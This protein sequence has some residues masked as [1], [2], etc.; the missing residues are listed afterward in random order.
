MN[1]MYWLNQLLKG[2]RYLYNLFFKK[3]SDSQKSSSESFSVAPVGVGESQSP[4]SN[5]GSSSVNA[6]AVLSD[7]SIEIIIKKL[8]DTKQI[9]AIT[10]DMDK[11]KGDTDKLRESQFSII[12]I[13][14]IFV[15]LFTFISVEFQIFRSFTSWKAGASLTLI[16]LGSLLFFI[17]VIGLILNRNLSKKIFGVMFA[18]FIFIIMGVFLFAYAGINNPEYISLEA[19]DLNERFIDRTEEIKDNFY[20]K[21]EVELIL[22]SFKDCIWNN[23]LSKCLK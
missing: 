5:T 8:L 20:T 7:Q 11:L 21:N 19:K 16:L 23:G 14:G 9:K 13:L 10:D 2:F 22:K 3:F 4:S 1:T 17:V 15:A 6:K 18:A 12:E